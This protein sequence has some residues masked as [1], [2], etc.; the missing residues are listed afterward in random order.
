M[1]IQSSIIGGII[2]ILFIKLIK[3]KT[4]S[5][6]Y[7]LPPGPTPLP[8]IGCIIQMLQNKP[9]FRWIHK[10]IDD[11]NSPIISIRLGQ[12]THV[13]VVSSPIIAREFLK[14]QDEIF[15]SR[16]DS[17]S[18]YLISDGYR[19][20]IMSPL[21]DQ[22][23]MMRKILNQDILSL[24]IHK[25]LQPKRDEEANHL[26][27]Y[28][29]SQIEN[30]NSPNGGG[31]INI[32]IASQ[33]FCGNLIRNM[34]FGTRFFGEGMADGGPGG[35]ETE[36]VSALFIIL[37]Y[38][39]AFCISDYFP[40][41]RWK[42]DFDGHEKIIRTAIERV[43]KYHD[44]LVDERIK[45][46]NDGARKQEEDVLDI[47]IKHKEPKLSPEEIK[48]QIIE[49][50]I[51]TIDNPS[52]AVEWV[53]AEMISEPTILKRAVEELDK[54]V[55]CNRL[56]KESDLPQLNYIK[57]CIKESFRLHPF[58]P[59]NVPH[60]SVKDTV[61]A[62]YFIPKG[63]HVL[64]SRL[65]L[66]RNPN[67]WKDP[68]RFD[69][70]RHL[71]EEGKQVVLTDNELRMLSFST[72][73]RGC[74]GVILGSTITIMLLARM[75]QGFAWEKPY[76]ESEIKLVENHHDLH[77]AKSLVALAKPRLPWYLYPKI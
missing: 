28:M 38:L 8:F 37:N 74:P 65:G 11:Y 24:P 30:Q 12:A 73:K 69:P 44:P 58:A 61:V 23:R 17:L 40:L 25:W 77:M 1:I 57:A 55:G 70:D 22:W 64:L 56:V 20:T 63:S 33:H 34:V 59:F 45:L 75:I 67:V 9:T 3:K 62:G 52:N 72:G 26:L 42:T 29:I 6:P 39:N 21:G 13:I 19:S 31:L 49:L 35:E 27:S 4:S 60:V 16:P 10:L 32:R 14:T 51:A 71:G 76:N 48:A 47:L 2:I 53:M 50:M 46:W 66:G 54:V 5:S 68:M 18:G 15:S 43:R 7:Q 41:L 36:H